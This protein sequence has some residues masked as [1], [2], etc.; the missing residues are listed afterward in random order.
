MER[1]AADASQCGRGDFSEVGRSLRDQLIAYA[2]LSETS[3]VL[4]IGCGTGRLAKPLSE[5]LAPSSRYVGFDVSLTAVIACRRHIGK[6]HSNFQFLKADATNHEYNPLGQI[7]ENAYVFPAD[8]ADMDV[9]V[10]FS[11]FSH[12][13]QRSINHY[14]FEAHRV[15]RPGGR[16]AFTAYALTPERI[17]AIDRGEGR[18]RFRPWYHGAMTIDARSPER[19]I[20][21]PLE[22][23]TQGVLD[24]GLRL[25][26]EFLAGN[27]IGTPTYDGGQDLFVV[28]KD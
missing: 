16:F 2:G 22:A 8:E 28:V 23:L 3:D 4:D 21:H 10:A 14:L 27:W 20:A 17:A 15:L 9:V 6:A 26:Q 18:L 25:Q 12:M 5:Y 13:V 1:T 24:A 11:V 7:Q 19:A